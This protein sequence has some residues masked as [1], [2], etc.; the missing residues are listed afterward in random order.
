MNF[1]IATFD[2]VFTD[3]DGNNLVSIFNADAAIRVR[4][5]DIRFSYN[6]KSANQKLFEYGTITSVH[7]GGTV[8][9]KRPL[10]I[11]GSASDADVTLRSRAH[12]ATLR[13]EHGRSQNIK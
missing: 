13:S 12:T 2:T 9:N 4:L 1:F 11:G 7:S 8:L 6:Q 10:D 5:L 3:S